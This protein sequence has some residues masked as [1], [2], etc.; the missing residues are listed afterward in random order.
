NQL[1]VYLA[2]DQEDLTGALN[3]YLVR[4]GNTEDEVSLYKQSGTTLTKIIDGQDDVLDVSTVGIRVKV[5]RDENGN[6]ELLRDADGGTS[7]T[8]EGSVN[9]VTFTSSAYFGF[10]CDYTSTRSTLFWMDEIAIDQVRVDTVVINSSTEIEVTFNQQ[11][12]QP[13]VENIA[14]YSIGGLTISSATQDDSDA[15]KVVLALDETTPL[16]TSDYTLNIEAGLT[17][18][19]STAYDFSYVSLDLESLLT[20]SDTEVQ[21]T[22]NAE[23]D[24]ISAETLGN[25]SIDNGIGQPTAAELDD[26]DQKVVTL[27]LTNPLFEST[28]FQLTVSSVENQPQ[29]STFSGTEDFTF[30]IPVVI[31]TLEA[32]SAN[33]IIVRFNKTLNQSIAETETNYSL[34]G[35]GGNPTTATLQSDAKSVELTFGANFSDATYTL[36]VNDLEDTD[37]NKI[38]ADSQD[39]FDYLNLAISSVTQI[40]DLSILVSFNQDVD[41]STAENAANYSIS[42]IGTATSAVRSAS[43]QNQV[44][45]SWS[46][47]YNSTYELTVSDV[48][49]ADLN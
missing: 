2:S 19:A 42:E 3:G 9:D 12:A 15:T 28:T 33:Q 36:T 24:E 32:I 18:N 13:D 47:L 31:D 21:L 37:G 23:L 48:A 45:V 11:I 44:T 39:S 10:R 16:T 6:W 27:T 5:V 40:D 43:N 17:K 20:L 25:Y 4:L 8:S 30:I 38:A 14:H 46:E 1:F 7:Y 26:E 49:N 22:F 34:D 35:S 41:E 29:N